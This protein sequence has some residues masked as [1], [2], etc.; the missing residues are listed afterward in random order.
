MDIEEHLTKHEEVLRALAF[1]YGRYNKDLRED[2][3]QAGVEA[4]MMAHKRWRYHGAE[5]LTYAWHD[6]KKAMLKQVKLVKTEYRYGITEDLDELQEM[7]EKV[8]GR[9]GKDGYPGKRVHL[10]RLYDEPIEGIKPS[11][12]SALTR[13]EQELAEKL[14]VNLSN[15]ELVILDASVG[16][17]QRQAADFLNLSKST[18]VR[19]LEEIQ[20]K[21]RALASSFAD[22]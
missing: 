22:G 14:L 10:D 20:A 18:Y 15:E 8:T 11:L 12:E 9:Y 13:D 19:R 2:C 4:L 1:Q 6:V 17:S 3:Y 7:A 21:A 16:R 5:L